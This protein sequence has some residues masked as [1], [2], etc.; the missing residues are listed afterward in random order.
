MSIGGNSLPIFGSTLLSWGLSRPKQLAEALHLSSGGLTYVMDQL[1]SDG[2]VT[3]TYGEAADRRAVFV[4]LSDTGTK[5]GRSM[6]SALAASAPE[7]CAAL[8][9]TVRGLFQGTG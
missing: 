4:Q 3:R 2:I 9:L 6:C 8:S 5:H 7:I 1:E